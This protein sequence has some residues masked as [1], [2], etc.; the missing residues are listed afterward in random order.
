MRIGPWRHASAARK[1][2]REGLNRGVKM[3][4]KQSF[5]ASR[6]IQPP[7]DAHLART[8]SCRK[9]LHR[10]RRTSRHS[11]SPIMTTAR[12]GFLALTTLLALAVGSS[13]ERP[14]EGMGTGTEA[15][16]APW[17]A[18]RALRTSAP[19]LS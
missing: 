12:I 18:G 10:A 3:H 5:V 8:Q 7:V 17:N 9:L 4:F 6:R 2:W 13:G 16:C 11:G 14:G 19:P 15:C 1:A